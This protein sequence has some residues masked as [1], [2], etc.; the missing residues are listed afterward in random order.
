MNTDLQINGILKVQKYLRLFT[1]LFT[2]IHMCKGTTILILSTYSRIVIVV[3]DLLV[4]NDNETCSYFV[5]L[6]YN[7]TLSPQDR[8]KSWH[9]TELEVLR[10]NADIEVDISIQDIIHRSYLFQ[11]LGDLI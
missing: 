8:F 4:L 7:C 1:Y 3:Y 10:R 5:S 9:T 11:W 6:S 2:L